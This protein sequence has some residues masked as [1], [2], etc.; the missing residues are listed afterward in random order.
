MK[1]G[2]LGEVRDGLPVIFR[3]GSMPLRG[4]RPDENGVGMRYPGR[5]TISDG[6]RPICLWSLEAAEQAGPG[7]HGPDP[8]APGDGE[9]AGQAVDGATR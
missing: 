4:T 2:V 7:L 9:P 5:G 6:L 3:A 8:G 1:I